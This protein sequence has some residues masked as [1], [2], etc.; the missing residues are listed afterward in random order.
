MKSDVLLHACVFE[1]FIKVT[2]NESDIN[3]L[4]CVSSPGYTWQCGLKYT[5]IKLQTLQE[6]LI[7]NIIKGGISSVMVIDMLKVVIIK[8]YYV[9]ILIIDMV[10][11]CLNYYL[12]IKF[13][14]IE[15][16]N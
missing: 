14:L 7:E 11:Q 9:Q 6:K 15:M 1:K 10:T 13:N 4:N 5:D 8:R 12:M 16:L 2:V 3:P